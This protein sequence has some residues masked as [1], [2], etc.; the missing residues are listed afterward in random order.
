MS[1]TGYLHPTYIQSLS[2][3]GEPVF[4]PFCEGMILKRKILGTHFFDAVGPYPIFACHNWSGLR[5]DFAEIKTQFVSLAM[6]TD[7]FGDY[8]REYLDSLFDV[9][10]PYKEHFVVDLEQQ[11]QEFVS[12]HHLRNVEKA[13]KTI[14]VD[15]CEG[16]LVKC[17]DDWVML[18][19]NLIIRHNIKGVARFSYDSF[20]NQLKTP[21]MVAFRAL[22]SG[23]VVG[24]SLWY[25][26]NGVAY[27]HLAAYDELGYRHL[28]SFALFWYTIEYF[29]R[30]RIKWLSLGA[31]AGVNSQS[32]GLVRFKKGWSTG[33]RM[34]FLCGKVFNNKT[35]QALTMQHK[36]LNTDYFPAYRL[37]EF[38]E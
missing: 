6:V 2:Q 29:S 31:G 9:V 33:T 28:A 24:M 34:A 12:K 1:S 16:S 3:I 23:D 27:Y 10:R 25:I 32:D 21:G 5:E 13:F 18:Y 11:P 8:T 17:L 37:D 38:V 15:V 20:A 36:Q 26:Q 4:L 35:Y 14:S 22:Y 30:L 19:S 7:P